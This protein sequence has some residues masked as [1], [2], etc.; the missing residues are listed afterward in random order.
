MGS[1]PTLSATVRALSDPPG[2]AHLNL[3]FVFTALASLIA[4]VFAAHVAAQ[5]ARR[6]KPHQ[7]IW[8]VALVLFA[9]A[10]GCEAGAA[11][12]GWSVPLYRA[13]YLFGA[14]LGVVYLG[15]GSL[16]LQVSRR[17]A[18]VV[19]WIVVA[20][21]LVAAWR[22]ATAPVELSRAFA[23]SGRI[24]A[25]GFPWD[26]RLLITPV[27]NTFGTVM[28]VGGALWSAWKFARKGLVGRQTYGLVALAVGALVVAAGSLLDRFGVPQPFAAALFLGILI[29]AS[30]FLFGLR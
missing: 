19:T 23:A 11:V 15:L 30:G 12:A 20:I 29:M 10:T 9:V 26:T 8:T 18:L 3:E 25:A 1:N 22:V 13:W 27:L 24:T 5:Y 21:S 28:L 4:L 6:R 14:V 17:A 16:W 7:L 2:D